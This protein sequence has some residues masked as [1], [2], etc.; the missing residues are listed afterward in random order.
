MKLT[1]PTLLLLLM[2][3]CCKDEPNCSSI[4]ETRANF[5]GYSTRFYQELMKFNFP[6]REFDTSWGVLTFVA[7][8]IEDATYYKWIIGSEEIENQPIVTRQGFPLK[9][10]V[11][12][13]FIVHKKPNKQC[14][15]NDNG[16]DTLT[17]IFHFTGDAARWY[18]PDKSYSYFRGSFDRS[19][20]DSFTFYMSTFQSDVNRWDT[21]YNF[22]CQGDFLI[23]DIKYGEY[24][25]FHASTGF[26]GQNYKCDSVTTFYFTYLNNNSR[27][28][29][30]HTYSKN[31][32][33][34]TVFRGYELR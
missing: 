15:P 23:T 24:N 19:P 14:F 3:G 31:R 6:F 33:D 34:S 11:A 27:Q 13:D 26:W 2:A 10:S 25:F 9:G 20:R 21:I 29:M 12:V 28:V 8:D 7:K 17:K 32:R 16:I 1:I 30:I 4:S 22:P 5:E 18:R